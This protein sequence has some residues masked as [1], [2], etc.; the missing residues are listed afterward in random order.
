VTSKGE[1]QEPDNA[2]LGQFLRTLNPDELKKVSGDVFG[3]IYE[4]YLTQFAD[5]KACDA[6]QSNQWSTR[7]VTR[8]RKAA[9]EARHRA[10]G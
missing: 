4:Y 8:V 7:D 6:R 10:V 3:R 5:Q 9:D 2:V 1:Y